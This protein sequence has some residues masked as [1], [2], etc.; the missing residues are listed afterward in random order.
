M[1]LMHKD[2]YTS[3]FCIDSL[4]VV[5][6][7]LIKTLSYPRSTRLCVACSLKGSWRLPLA[8]RTWLT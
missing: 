7:N 1:F 4:H 6:A 8:T 5:S 2:V 3:I